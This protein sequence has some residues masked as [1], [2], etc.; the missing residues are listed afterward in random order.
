VSHLTVL[1]RE[2]LSQL[3]LGQVV[4]AALVHR[5]SDRLTA[6]AHVT[7]HRVL[8]HVRVLEVEEGAAAAQLHRDRVVLELGELPEELVRRGL[9]LSALARAVQ[10]RVQPRALTRQ[11]VPAV[12]GRRVVRNLAAVRVPVPNGAWRAQRLQRGVRWRSR[13]R[14]RSPLQ[15]ALGQLGLGLGCRRR[16]CSLRDGGRG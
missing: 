5:L 7:Q 14:N 12:H 4:A 16:C 3:A 1:Q 15:E 13:N 11:H 2:G 10:Q 8:V 9:E 6:P